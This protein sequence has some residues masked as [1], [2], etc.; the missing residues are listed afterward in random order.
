MEN[1]VINIIRDVDIRSLPRP[2]RS[3]FAFVLAS[4]GVVNQA[5]FRVCEIM[6]CDAPC[7]HGAMCV[8]NNVNALLT[9]M[10][11]PDT[12]RRGL[13]A[14]T[15]WWVDMKNYDADY[16]A[17]FF[18]AALPILSDIATAHIRE[19]CVRFASWPVEG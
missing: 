11:T 12:D 3:L 9:A 8:L 17:K 10:N 16:R 4:D 18:A 6:L 2:E 1:V 15:D 13:G 5:D 7:A 14:V 19:R